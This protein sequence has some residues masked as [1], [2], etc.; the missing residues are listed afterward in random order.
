MGCPGWG[1]RQAQTLQN[2]SFLG[3]VR[4]VSIFLTNFREE[5][6][7]MQSILQAKEAAIVGLTKELS[8]TRARMSDMR[9][10]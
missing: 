9:G 4:F 7:A 2:E 3:A 8:E 1:L 10:W 5:L 6:A